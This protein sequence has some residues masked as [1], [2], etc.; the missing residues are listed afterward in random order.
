MSLFCD[1]VIANVSNP[2]NLLA[3]QTQSI[4]LVEERGVMSSTWNEKFLTFTKTKRKFDAC[5]KKK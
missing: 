1:A 3:S 4:L 2:A 5:G